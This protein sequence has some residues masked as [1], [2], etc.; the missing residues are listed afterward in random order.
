[1]KVFFFVGGELEKG[2]GVLIESRAGASE[3]LSEGSTMVE[4]DVSQS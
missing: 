3:S 4:M 1:M 2:F